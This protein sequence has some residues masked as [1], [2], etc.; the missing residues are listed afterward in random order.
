MLVQIRFLVTVLVV[1]NSVLIGCN[2]KSE[3]VPVL[4]PM[5]ASFT[6]SLNFPTLPLRRDTVYAEQAVK[7]KVSKIQSF[8]NA[9]AL[10]LSLA[11]HRDTVRFI[12]PTSTYAS[13]WASSYSFMSGT[14]PTCTIQVIHEYSPEYLINNR[15]VEATFNWN[16]GGLSMIRHDAKHKLISG[17]F[18]YTSDGYIGLY[19]TNINPNVFKLEVSGSF[20][21]VSIE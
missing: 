11:A 18:S 13:S 2:K 10:M 14:C 5:S 9:P 12:I 7:I 4:E 15:R 17:N 8:S 21:N 19:T 6:R 1:S 20:K 3:V 16:S